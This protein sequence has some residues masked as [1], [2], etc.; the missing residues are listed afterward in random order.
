MP[1]LNLIDSIIMII[2]FIRM[3]PFFSNLYGLNA[4]L[5]ELD[6]LSSGVP[7]FLKSGYGKLLRIAIIYL[8]TW[9]SCGICVMVTLS[10]PETARAAQRGDST[11]DFIRELCPA[12]F[13]TYGR[14]F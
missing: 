9:V 4:V 6:E 11:R 12:I 8:V 1:S 5:I 13:Y 10:R 2:L 7:S 14:C 3:C